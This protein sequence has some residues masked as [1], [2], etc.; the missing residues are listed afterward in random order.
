MAKKPEK[1]KQAEPKRKLGERIHDRLVAAQVAAEEAAGYGWAT[2][3]VEAAEAA[4]DPEHELSDKDAGEEPAEKPA[5]KPVAKA[6]ADHP[7]D[8]KTGD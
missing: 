3:A 1:Q 8:G 6:S 4:V 7:A 5:E 2:E